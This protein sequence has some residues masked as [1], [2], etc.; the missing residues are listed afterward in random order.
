MSNNTPRNRRSRTLPISKIVLGRSDAERLFASL[1]RDLFSQLPLTRGYVEELDFSAITE[2]LPP[3]YR[4]VTEAIIANDPVMLLSRV[5]SWYPAPHPVKV[6][7]RY[8][9]DGMKSLSAIRSN[10][11]NEQIQQ[12]D[13]LAA[14]S[15]RSLRQ[16]FGFYSRLT[17][18]FDQDDPRLTESISDFRGR[19]TE[20]AEVEFSPTFYIL[21]DQFWKGVDAKHI[22]SL[23]GIESLDSRFYPRH[24]PGAVAEKGTKPWQ[25]GRVARESRPWLLGRGLPLDPYALRRPMME[26]FVTYNECTDPSFLWD[27]EEWLRSDEIH[28]SRLIPVPK[29]FRGPRLIAAEP[30]AL[31]Y[32]QGAID[33]LLDIHI[34]HSFLRKVFQVHDQ[35]SQRM[36]AM[37]ASTDSSLVTIDMKDASDLVRMSHVRELCRSRPD[38]WYVLSRVRSGHCQLPNGEVVNLSSFTTMGAMLTFKLEGIVFSLVDLAAIIDHDRDIRGWKWFTHFSSKFLEDEISRSQLGVYGDDQLF[39]SIY[40]HSCV[41]AL[42]KAGFV[43]NQ[44]KCCYKGAFREACGVDAWNGHD[45]TAVRPRALPGAVAEKQSLEGH[46][47]TIEN[48]ANKGYCSAAVTLWQIL[49]SRGL[50]IPIVPSDSTVACCVASDLLYSLGDQ[51]AQLLS[52]R[53]GKGAIGNWRVWA[54]TQ[55]TEWLT[56]DE[57][58]EGAYWSSLKPHSEPLETPRYPGRRV[59]IKRRPHEGYG[60]QPVV[61]TKATASSIAS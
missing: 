20:D 61:L 30:C 16:Y 28:P 24:G 37:K 44:S 34:K 35:S 51:P 23:A 4:D 11:G 41:S 2:V 3:R 13:R 60:P 6:W 26:D 54:P 14:L 1:A 31:Q 58:D 19:V 7:A 52:S 12:L 33:E 10:V 27:E 5:E 50:T 22:F 32:I 17:V 48:L 40:Y 38:I 57:L 47:E 18:K 36:A 43:V 25:K 15:I 21:A 53:Y 8:A 46:I 39:L 56:P 49:A 9:A 59:C 29:D 42:E 45:V 55:E